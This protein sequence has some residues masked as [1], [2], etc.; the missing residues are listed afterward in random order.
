MPGPVPGIHVL[1]L[2]TKGRHDGRVESGH[3]EERDSSF[4]LQLSAARYAFAPS[5]TMSG[6][7]ANETAGEVRITSAC[8]AKIAAAR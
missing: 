7:R 3:D 4:V 1:L 8:T 5:P 6:W 2:K